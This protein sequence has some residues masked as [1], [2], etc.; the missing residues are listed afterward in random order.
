M[1]V[2]LLP[3]PVLVERSLPST[4]SVLLLVQLYKPVQPMPKIRVS[5]ATSDKQVTYTPSVT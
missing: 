5:L 2:K 3:E 4:D 1:Y